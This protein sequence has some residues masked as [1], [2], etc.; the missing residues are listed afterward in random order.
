MYINTCFTSCVLHCF[1]CTTPN[2]WLKMSV[3]ISDDSSLDN[4]FKEVGDF[5]LFQI[6]TYILVCIPNILSA[7]YEVNYMISANTLDYR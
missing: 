6:I 7:T 5:G 3:D 4:I 1:F 2:I